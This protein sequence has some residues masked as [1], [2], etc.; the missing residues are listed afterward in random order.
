MSD[1]ILAYHY[2]LKRGMWAAPYMNRLAETLAGWGFNCVVYEIED[3]LRFARG[4]GFAHADALDGRQTARVVADLRA[5]GLDV[6][7]LMQSLGHAEC[8]LAKGE[9]AHLRESDAHTD[10]YHPLSAEARDW[11]IDL[12]DEIIDVFQPRQ[13]VHM[14]GDET[15]H[16]GQSETCRP[17][18]EQIGVGGLYLRH[19]M[20]LFEHIRSRGLRPIIWADIVLAHPEVL[21]QIPRYVVLMDWDYAVTAERRDRVRVWGEG[22]LTWPQLQ[23]RDLPAFHEHL[24]PHCVDEQTRRDATFPAFGTT[25]ALRA[26]GFDVLTASA[27]KCSG[28]TAGVPLNSM[29]APNVFHSA[30]KGCRDGLGNLVT[31]WA[32]RHNHPETNLAATYAGPQALRADGPFDADALAREFTADYYGVEMGELAEAMRLAETRVPFSQSRLLVVA[33]A[34]LAKGKEPLVDYLAAA[35]EQEGGRAAE[36]RQVTEALEGFAAARELFAGM[37]GKAKRNA[38]N[39]DYW[40][41]GVELVSFYADFALCVLDE[42]LA[43]LAADLTAR[44]ESLRKAT[45]ALFAETYTPRGAAEEL[46]L[47]YGFHETCLDNLARGAK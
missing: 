7:P 14:G 8:V 15:R 21:D 6:I 28:D 44:L 10:Q 25:D 16:L 22:T 42:T 31:S 33:S 36:R 5:R 34:E 32:V 45:A 46:A 37:R 39:L 13:F 29:H 43:D 17:V 20:P 30:R 1:R 26:M 27:N 40:L 47:R 24:G 4:P 11:L 23:E 35:D 41:E 2:D 9:F 3:K 18:V 38:H 12:F 19:M